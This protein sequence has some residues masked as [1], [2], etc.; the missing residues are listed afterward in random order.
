MT[1][2]EYFSIRSEPNQ[3]QFSYIDVSVKDL[4]SARSLHAGS[5]N[6]KLLY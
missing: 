4:Q 3:F 2:S 6:R 1:T 5:T